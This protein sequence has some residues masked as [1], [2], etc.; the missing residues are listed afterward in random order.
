MT[1]TSEY[2][3]TSPID[4]NAI[5]DDITEGPDGCNSLEEDSL[6]DVTMSWQ[7]GIGQTKERVAC[8][9]SQ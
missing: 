9:S 8:G 6:E 7:W 4:W 5:T 1:G 3:P 2:M